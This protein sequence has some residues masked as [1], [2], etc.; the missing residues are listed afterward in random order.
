MAGRLVHAGHTPLAEAVHTDA[1]YWP[2]AH[3]VQLVGAVTPWRQYW[4]AGQASCA[5][6]VGQK[7]AAAHRF[8]CVE[9]SGQ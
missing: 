1:T 6:T 7:N 3:M 2:L 9:P 4:L 5:E 8:C